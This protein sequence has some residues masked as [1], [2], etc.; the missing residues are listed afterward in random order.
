MGGA[1]SG[2]LVVCVPR[3]NQHIVGFHY[4]DVLFLCVCPSSKW[5]NF[6][7]GSFRFT[8]VSWLILQ[9][10]NIHTDWYL[11]KWARMAK[12]DRY[13]PEFLPRW[14]NGIIGSGLCTR[15]DLTIMVCIHSGCIT[16]F[17]FFIIM[18]KT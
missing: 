17:S 2:W 7:C 3:K 11:S 5:P 10:F 12:I 18:G 15:T 13:G 16:L 14:N 4:C 8:K 9:F 1:N 6:W